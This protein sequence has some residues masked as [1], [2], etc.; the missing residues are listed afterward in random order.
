MIRSILLALDDTPGACAARDVA[1]ALARRTGAAVT[2]LI[3]LDRPHTSAAHEAV[4]MGGGAFAARRNEKLAAAVE[5]E[6]EGVLA[7]A[8]VAAGDLPFAVVRREEAPEQALLAEG[9]T[10]DLIIIGRDCTLGREACDDGLSPTIEALLRDGARPLL[11]VPPGTQSA[12]LAEVVQLTHPILIAQNGS[13]AAMR[14][15][16]VFALLGLGKGQAVKLLDFTADASPEALARYLT[17][18]GMQAEAFAVRG[19]AHDIL[20]AEAQSLPASLLVLG[21]D[22]ESGIS[23][24]IFGSATARLLRAAPCPVFIHG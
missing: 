19:D 3:V 11:V 22:Q 18:H 5:A 4:P 21:A 16:H 24:L 9:A 2:A 7:D 14:T 10:H 12:G 1:F 6:A 23:R 13:M 17:Q 8:R 20:L 15:L